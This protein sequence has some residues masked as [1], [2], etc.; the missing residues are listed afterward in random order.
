MGSSGAL[1]DGC[2]PD[3]RRGGP[4]SGTRGRT[5]QRKTRRIVAVVPTIA[6]ACW[7]LRRGESSVAPRRARPR[8]KLSPYAHHGQGVVRRRR[9]RPRHAPEHDHRPWSR[10]PT[11]MARTVVTTNSDLVSAAIAAIGALK[12]PRHGGPYRGM[13]AR[14]GSRGGRSGSVCVEIV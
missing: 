14:L 10:P 4:A 13:R 12:S 7:R 2:V 3:R 9:A 5:I 6:V 8:G 1:A 11:V